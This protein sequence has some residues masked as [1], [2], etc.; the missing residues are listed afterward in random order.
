ML[1]HMR[2]N[3]V[4]HMK[5]NWDV[6]LGS[7]F[8]TWKCCTCGTLGYRIG[9]QSNQY[10]TKIDTAIHHYKHWKI[11]TDD[12]SHNIL[13]AHARPSLAVL[14]VT[15]STRLWQ[16]LNTYASLCLMYNSDWHT[17]AL[18]RYSAVEFYVSGHLHAHI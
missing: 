11:K 15:A 16:A 5:I 6:H 12:L 8:Q 2:V 3:S 18:A 4:T 14:H 7:I 9:V 10:L 17:D 1:V 13:A